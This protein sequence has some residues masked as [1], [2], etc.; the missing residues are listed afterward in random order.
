MYLWKTGEC[1]E[2]NG[3]KGH[4]VYKHP[5]TFMSWGVTWKKCSWQKVS[6]QVAT[7]MLTEY[8]H[9]HWVCGNSVVHTY[10]GLWHVEGVSMF[11]GSTQWLTV[12]D[13]ETVFSRISSYVHAIDSFPFG[14]WQ[15]TE[16]CSQNWSYIQKLSSPR[17]NPVNYDRKWRCYSAL[18]AADSWVPS[19]SP[20][21]TPP[22][23]SNLREVR[24]IRS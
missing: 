19:L 16:C 1:C 2:F 21:F 11:C 14:Y 15:C 22:L 23:R 6:V 5:D 3:V 18:Q 9:T 20:H 7:L 4:R 8:E 13:N 24:I 12:S 17:Y 10:P